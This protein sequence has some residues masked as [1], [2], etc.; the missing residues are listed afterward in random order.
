MMRLMD[1][2][3]EKPQWEEK[4]FNDE[5]TGK[6]RR[7]IADS[8]QDVSPKMMDWI[9]KELQWKAKQL[10]ENGYILVFDAGV[11][12]SDSA[13]PEDVR[14]ALKQAVQPLE[15][16]PEDQKDFHPGT[17][18]QVVD[19][20]HPSLFP[21]IFGRTRVLADRTIGLQDCLS[22]VGEGDLLTSEP[23]PDPTGLQE[24]AYSKRFQW[25]PCDVEL[26]NDTCHIVSYINNAH[27]IHHKDLYGVIEQII[28]RAL[29]LWNQSLSEIIDP[30]IEYKGV[31][32]GPHPPEP[33]ESDGE[34]HDEEA[35]DEI[36][37]QWRKARPI[38]Q[39]E[40]EDFKPP[41]TFE[42]LD[43]RAHFWNTKLQVIVKLANID[44]NPSNPT[45]KGGSW[46]IEG[47]LNERICASAIY[48]Y[49]CENI[50]E[51]KLAFR[52]RGLN[53]MV[54]LNYEQNEHQ[55]LQAVYGFGDDIWGGFNN[56][57]TQEL[58]AVTCK[59]GR[60]L[61]FPN[62][63]QHRVSPFSLADPSKP[64]HRKILALFLVDP[65]R[66]IISS[67]NVPPQR[68]DWGY[69]KEQAVG[70]VL[71]RLPR[72]LQDVIQGDSSP[73][74]TMEEA[75]EHRLELMKERGLSSK[76]NNEN[77]ESGSF[78]LCEH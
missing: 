37:R 17:E 55:F 33:E 77:F 2:I 71:S 53:E 75:K 48:Y 43:L 25:L 44:L 60:L 15:N 78:S 49:D 76:E 5:I 34:D 8:G 28:S 45:Y 70:Q 59:E 56:N 66:R 63:V 23:L 4:V 38:I 51:S 73:L 32:Y 52:Q 12:K 35:F 31:E 50:T 16:V 42:D 14:E 65:H 61:T 13:I 30:R 69:E 29:P 39:P 3:T 36:H 22:S 7:E 1:T 72:E 19:L 46:H 11:I 18:K 27:P 40:P 67:A 54:D 9:I 6:W 68:E 62:T 10:E 21:V 41:V 24:L 26:L 20:V 74:M 64:G 47:Q 57:I 58:G